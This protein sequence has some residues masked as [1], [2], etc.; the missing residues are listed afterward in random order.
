VK[1]GIRVNSGKNRLVHRVFDS[2]G[3]TI[4]KLDRM[5]FAGLTKKNLSRGEYRLLDTKEIDFLK[6]R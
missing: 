1:I 4:E 2:L 6:T 3:Y 5:S